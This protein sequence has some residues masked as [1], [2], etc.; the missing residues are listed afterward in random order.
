MKRNL[1]LI[2]GG[3]IAK[4]YRLGLERSETLRL[5]SLVD[6][7]PECAA[8][9]CFDVP[10][11]TDYQRALETRPEIAVLAIPP[12][13]REK[14]A[15]DLLS[16]GVAVATEKPMLGSPEKI[17]A[18]FAYANEKQ[19]PLSCLFH[20][21]KAEEVMFLKAR[22]KDYGPV[23]S[24]R[25]VIHDDYA[26][27]PDGSIRPDRRGL[28]GAWY[29]SGIN[30]LSYYGELFDLSRATLLEDASCKDDASGQFR[31]ARRVFDFS[32][33]RAEIVV[34][35][36]TPSRS[37]YT[38]IVCER[39][40]LFVDHSA[41]TVTF[42]GETVFSAPTGDRLSSHY[43]NLFRHF[44][45]GEDGEHIRLLHKILYTGNAQ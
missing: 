45:F 29:D 37:K 43:D 38:E 31:Y 15:Y 26:A 22:L 21:Q 30:V 19:V 34:D 39:G 23:R 41:Q 12:D 35:W 1:M 27:T 7:D 44:T 18:L 3:V 33:V 9:S 17:D 4:H 5:V 28:L 36:T 10:F 13:A 25:T 2:G 6:L 8:R 16:R 40:A 24:L 14:T 20:W 11:Y 32:G 42:N